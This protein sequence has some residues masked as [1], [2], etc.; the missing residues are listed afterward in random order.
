M[1]SVTVESVGAPTRRARVTAP[2]IERALKTAVEG[3]PGR[4]VRLLPRS[5]RMNL[6]EPPG[7][8]FWPMSLQPV[9]LYV[10]VLRHTRQGGIKK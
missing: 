6:N 5:V 10:H 8:V 2:S 9:R 3:K 1:K 7:S 4:G